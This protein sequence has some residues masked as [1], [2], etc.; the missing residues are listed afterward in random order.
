MLGIDPHPL[1]DLGAF[2]TEL[3]ST[4]GE[5]CS[6]DWLLALLRLDAA[7]PLVRDEAVRQ[8]VR[9]LF[10]HGGYKPT[11][12]GKPA[13]EYLVRAAQEDALN[14]INPVVDV[15]NAVSLHSGLPISLV[16][17]DAARPP[18][19]VGIVT[20][21]VGYV[22]NASG[23]EIRVGGL[24]C[25]HD[26]LGPCA[27]GVKDSERTKTGPSTRR[28]LSLVWGVRGHQERTARTVAWYRALLEK[29]GGRTSP[30]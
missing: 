19:R 13:S 23:Q 18:L 3:P 1:L 21:D 8:S 20:D 5:M 2:A 16:D 12:R 14:S 15:C 9:D 10:R 17:S 27:N 30:L 6:P 29:L 11:G 7:A 26:A 22:F 25:L 24:L 28:T 4:L